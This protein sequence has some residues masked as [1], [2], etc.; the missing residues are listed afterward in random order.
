[1]KFIYS[2]LILLTLVSCAS[3]N[4]LYSADVEEII[5]QKKN[6][7]VLDVYNLTKLYF[8]NEDVEYLHKRNFKYGE[9]GGQ[10]KICS[11]DEYYCL[12]GG[13]G[14][15]IPKKLAGQKEWQF[16]DEKCH[17][18][19]PLSDQQPAI[20]TCDSEG[21]SNKF[22]YSFDRGITSYVTNAQPEFEHVLVDKKGLFA[23]PSSNSIGHEAT[24]KAD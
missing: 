13:I 12:I 18:E 20:I 3:R 1:M 7:H 21:W 11:N 14:V 15:V 19:S 17:S 9:F 4:K 2:V 6:T 10:I 22:V 23:N 8:S 24:H 16:A 5:Y